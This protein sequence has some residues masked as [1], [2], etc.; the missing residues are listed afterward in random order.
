MGQRAYRC[1]DVVGL[2]RGGRGGRETQTFS[3][4]HRVVILCWCVFIQIDSM[5]VDTG[6]GGGWGQTGVC[7]IPMNRS[8]GGSSTRFVYSEFVWV[9]LKVELYYYFI[10]II[11]FNT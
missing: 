1:L 3:P 9:T 11:I 6:Q 7:F 10:I 5:Y 2:Q 4:A 8:S